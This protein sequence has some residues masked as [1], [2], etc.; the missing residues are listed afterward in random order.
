M[1]SKNIMMYSFAAL[2]VVIL[3][4]IMVAI[5]WKLILLSL[6]GLGAWFV[7]N[8]FI[9]PKYLKWRAIENLKFD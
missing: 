4:K 6:I 3:L 7:F 9:R 1:N 8:R 2:A 5:S